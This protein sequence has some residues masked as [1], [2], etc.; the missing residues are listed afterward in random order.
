MNKFMF[1]L[2]VQNFCGSQKFNGHTSMQ[3][4]QDDDPEVRAGS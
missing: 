4:T 1:G 2:M 3:K